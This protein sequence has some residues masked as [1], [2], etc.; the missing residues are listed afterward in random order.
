MRKK[1]TFVFIVIVS[2]FDQAILLLEQR[3]IDV[4]HV[5]G[6]DFWNQNENNLQI[7]NPF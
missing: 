1:L 5:R 6:F 3:G 4:L 2:V 7:V